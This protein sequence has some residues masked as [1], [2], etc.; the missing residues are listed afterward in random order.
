[1]E[2]TPKDL[3]GLDKLFA[4]DPTRLHAFLV[5]WTLERLAISFFWFKFL[6][7]LYLLL[8]LENGRM[9][10]AYVPPYVPPPRT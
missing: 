7:V 6:G 3:T 5:S 2:V 1:M 10:H 4:A 8:Y 9:Y